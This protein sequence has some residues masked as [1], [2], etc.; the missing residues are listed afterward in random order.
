MWPRNKNRSQLA[1]NLRTDPGPKGVLA[2]IYR[3]IYTRLVKDGNINMSRL[4]DQWVTQH[5]KHSS[6]VGSKSQSKSNLID[7]LN[8]PTMTWSVFCT[9]LKFFRFTRV[10]IM[11]RCYDTRGN[12]QDFTHSLNLSN[13]YE[14][15]DE[16]E[17]DEN[18]ADDKKQTGGAE[19]VA[20]ETTSK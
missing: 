5:Y 4:M 3:Q 2:R 20:D 10:D 8:R 6:V 14:M 11:F 17:E 18:V 12:V 1:P 19:D 13:P 16:E 7:A 15:E 9:V